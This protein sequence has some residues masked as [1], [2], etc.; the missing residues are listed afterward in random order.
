MSTTSYFSLRRG[1][2]GQV[3]TVSLLYKGRAVRISS[4]TYT[5]GTEAFGCRINGHRLVDVDALAL[6]A[7]VVRLID[8]EESTK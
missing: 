1:G 5:D 3:R 7:R 2:A 4:F 8:K 6:E